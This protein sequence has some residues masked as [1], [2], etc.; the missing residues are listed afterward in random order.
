MLNIL[1]Y[2]K[3]QKFYIKARNDIIRDIEALRLTKLHF[4]FDLERLQ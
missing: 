3:H 4:N 2:Q 1:R